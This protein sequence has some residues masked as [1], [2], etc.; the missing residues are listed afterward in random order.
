M[1]T[2][3]IIMAY[4][5]ARELIAISSRKNHLLHLEVSG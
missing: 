4:S 3:G 2:L 5:E 1:I